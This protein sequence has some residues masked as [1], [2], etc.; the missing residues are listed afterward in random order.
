MG[1]FR[2][3]VLGNVDGKIGNVTGAQ[4]K[5]KATVRSR[6]GPRKKGSFTPRQQ[7][8]NAKFALMMGFLQQLTPL[9]NQTFDRSAKG[10]TGFNKAF[11]F[12]IV[13]AITGTFPSF[14]IDY[15]KVQLSRG[16]Q[17]GVASATSTSPSAGQVVISWSNTGGTTPQADD[18]AYVA[19]YNQDINHWVYLQGVA[20]RKAGTVTLD[21]P[22]LSGKAFHVYLGFTTSTGLASNSFYVGQVTVS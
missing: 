4:W 5:G 21:L 20:Q 16:S 14:T 19:A 11:A 13:Q 3:G 6:P 17:T 15:S 7:E 22:G 18:L 2:K 10:M 9:L 1:T 12:N 8:Q